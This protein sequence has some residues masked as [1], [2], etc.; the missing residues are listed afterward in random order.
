MEVG[1]K[2]HVTGRFIPGEKSLQYVLNRKLD[3][4]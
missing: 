3:K 1:G 4:S 2:L